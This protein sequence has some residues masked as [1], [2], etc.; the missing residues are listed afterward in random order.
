[1]QE[2]L[3][4]RIKEVVVVAGGREGGEMLK[5][6]VRAWRETLFALKLTV[7]A[8]LQDDPPLPSVRSRR[9]MQVFW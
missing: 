5:T 9:A 2:T 6:Q 3:A 8:S 4:V 1:M 7:A